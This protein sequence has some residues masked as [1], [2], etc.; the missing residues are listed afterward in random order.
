MGCDI[1]C[2][3]ERRGEADGWEPVL[4]PEPF[5]DRCYAWF[6]FLAGVRNYS[7]IKP[8][9]MPRGLPDSVSLEVKR[10]FL[11]W[12]DDAHSA[13][14]LS[15]SE[16]LEFDYGQTVEDR[17]DCGS[18]LPAGQGRKQTYR[19]FLGIRFFQ[20]LEALRL[21][22]VQRIVFWFDN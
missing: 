7:A 8:I 4:G 5:D 19:E 18:T 3:A 21:R 6:A 20:E 14:W 22:G 12:G 2:Y 10:E 11:R 1:H 15:L 9:S 13:S 17:R 16:L